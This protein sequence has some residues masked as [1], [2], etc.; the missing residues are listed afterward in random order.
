MDE[1]EATLTAFQKANDEEIRYRKVDWRKR[2]RLHRKT[3]EAKQK[4][5]RGLG[6]KKRT[7]L[8]LNYPLKSEIERAKKQ[9][10]PF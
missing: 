6:G 5:R 2:R 1:M 9:E 10:A 3:K 4:A 8:N 7:K